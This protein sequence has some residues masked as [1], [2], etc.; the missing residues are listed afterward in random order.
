MENNKKKNLLYHVHHFFRLCLDCFTAHS[1]VRLSF[2][3]STHDFLQKPLSLT[4][5]LILCSLFFR[6]YPFFPFLKVN[7]LRNIWK[8]YNVMKSIL[9]NFQ[10]ST[11]DI[12]LLRERLK[13]IWCS[14]WHGAKF[15]MNFW[16]ILMWEIFTSMNINSFYVC[17]WII[18]FKEINII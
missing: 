15:L 6:L 16:H 3:P 5:N 13:I 12:I 4:E 2:F 14:V 8:N 9:S 18:Q 17:I 7:L 11:I 1:T 10:L